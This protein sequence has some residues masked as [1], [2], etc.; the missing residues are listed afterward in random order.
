MP[1]H[2]RVVKVEVFNFFGMDREGSYDVKE[3]MSC[4]ITQLLKGE[5]PR[6]GGKKAPG[7]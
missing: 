5:E 3:L 4:E 1:G 6:I 2:F 7:A